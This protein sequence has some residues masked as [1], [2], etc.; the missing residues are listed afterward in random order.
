MSCSWQ[1]FLRITLSTLA[2][3]DSRGIYS[4]PGEGPVAATGI[5][6]LFRSVPGVLVNA[7]ARR[8]GAV[9]RSLP[10]RLPQIR[11]RE[12]SFDRCRCPGQNGSPGGGGRTADTFPDQRRVPRRERPIFVSDAIICILASLSLA[13]RSPRAPIARSNAT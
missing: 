11:E 13:T 7:N 1:I 10:D 9:R 3:A 6:P 4:V 2:S 8:R 12:A 5:E